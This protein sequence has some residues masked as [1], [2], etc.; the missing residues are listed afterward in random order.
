M[1]K[2]IVSQRI[3][4]RKPEKLSRTLNISDFYEKR[5][6]ILITRGVGG[7]GDIFMHRMIFEDIKRIM[8]D[9]EI[10]FACP[11]MYHAAIKDHPFIDKI[12]DCAQ[13]KK[14]DYIAHYNTTTACGRTEMKLAPYSA[15][16]R[17]DIWAMHCGMKLENHDMH[18]TLT[19]E[20]KY[21]ARELIKEYRDREGPCV[22]VCPISAMNNKNLLDHQLLG[23]MKGLHDRGCY[24]LGLHYFPIEVLEKN[25]IPTVGTQHKL[26]LW[27]AVLHEAEYVV[28]VDTAAFHCAGGMKKPLVGIFTFA[29]G[30]QYGAHYSTFELVQKHRDDDPCWTCGPCYNWGNCPKTKSNPKPCL[31]EITVDMIMDGVDRMFK[32]FPISE[33]IVKIPLM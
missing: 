31:T 6:K 1:S 33:Q 21:E 14:Q 8:P 27:M 10:H 13:V 24:T 2:K 4:R 29:D 19:D 28:S 3:E 12:L 9:C 17:S 26:R 7:L 32:R 30:K 15:P 23:L 18:I 5:N 22:V 20:E 25:N 11:T 16:N